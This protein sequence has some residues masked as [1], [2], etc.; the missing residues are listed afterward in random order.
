MHGDSSVVPRIRRP[1]ILSDAVGTGFYDGFLPT[2]L[3]SMG[4]RLDNSP[5]VAPYDQLRVHGAGPD[6]T[7]RAI[8]E[9]D[10]GD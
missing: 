8:P 5:V 6:N 2:R 3:V 10:V 7:L 1:A 4:V 9:E